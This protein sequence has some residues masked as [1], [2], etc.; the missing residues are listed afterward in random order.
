MA[1]LSDIHK[2]RPKI[3]DSLGALGTDAYLSCMACH[4]TNGVSVA[5][6]GVQRCLICHGRTD[7]FPAGAFGDATIFTKAVVHDIKGTG[8]LTDDICIICHDRP[9]MNGVFDPAVDLTNFSG[10]ASSIN[11]FCLSC[12]D[13]N[14]ASGILSPA[15]TFDPD[16]T[17]LRD[18]F[19]GF[20]STEVERLMTADIHGAK[21]GGVPLFGVFR[22]TTYKNGMVLSCVECHYPHSSGNPYLITESGAST[23][24]DNSTVLKATVKVTNN[25]FNELCAL[26]HT[27]PDGADAGN[28]LHEVVHKGFTLTDCTDCHFHGGGYGSLKSNLF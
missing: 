6:G 9:D 20:G 28:G 17:N 7:I 4:G 15:L 25:R 22:G 24:V 11:D 3:W 27:N 12:H 26:C 21:T 16:F 2:R 5:D 8:S 23:K 18:T 1:K 10:T 13:A 19:L 14:G